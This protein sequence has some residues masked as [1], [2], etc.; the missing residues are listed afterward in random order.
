MRAR[1]AESNAHG[2]FVLASGGLGEKKIGDI[3]AGDEKNEKDDDHECGEKKQ[4]GG[5]IAR[6]K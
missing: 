1:G 6:R 4:D 5:F 3:G 2:H